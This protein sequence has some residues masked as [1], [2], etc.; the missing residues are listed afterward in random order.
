[1]LLTS[2]IKQSEFDS[3]KHFIYLC[4]LNLIHILCLIKSLFDINANVETFIN[5]FYAQIN[6]ISL[7]SLEIPRDLRKFDNQFAQSE[8]IIHFVIISFQIS[9]H[10]KFFVMIKFL[11]ITLLDFDMIIKLN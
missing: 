7:I 10:F 6:N 2:H 3:E 1:M 9:K 11:I 8:F 5:H 4:T